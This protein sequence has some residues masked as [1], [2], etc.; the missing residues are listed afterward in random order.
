MTNTDRTWIIDSIVYK[1]SV[2]GEMD[3]EPFIYGS[4][5]S[6]CRAL[7][8]Q[9]LTMPALAERYQNRMTT[10]SQGSRNGLGK[11]RFQDV[12][13]DHSIERTPAVSTTNCK[14]WFQR[15]LAPRHKMKF[16]G[17]LSEDVIAKLAEEVSQ[18][19]DEAL[20]HNLDGIANSP[21]LDPF[22]T[23]VLQDATSITGGS[24]AAS[25]ETDI[26]K[27]VAA[28]V[29]RQQ[30]ILEIILAN[31]SRRLSLANPN[32]KPL[33]L[34]VNQGYNAQNVTSHDRTSLRTIAWP[35]TTPC[36]DIAVS[37]ENS[38]ALFAT[39]D[40]TRIGLNPVLRD[41]V[42][43]DLWNYEQKCWIVPKVLKR[44]QLFPYQWPSCIDS[45]CSPQDSGTAQ[46]GSIRLA[47]R[48]DELRAVTAR[49][50]KEKSSD[51]DLYHEYDISGGSFP[52]ENMLDQRADVEEE[53][54]TI[55]GLGNLPSPADAGKDMHESSDEL[56]QVSLYLHEL[57]ALM[58]WLQIWADM[59][60]RGTFIAFIGDWVHATRLCI[61]IPSKGILLISE[62]IPNPMVPQFDNADD[63][64]IDLDLQEQLI[65]QEVMAKLDKG[66]H[67][68]ARPTEPHL[69]DVMA[70]AT[71]VAL[72]LVCTGRGQ[73]YPDDIFQTILPRNI[74]GIKHAA[75]RSWK[76]AVVQHAKKKEERIQSLKHKRQQENKLT[77]TD[78]RQGPSHDS[79]P[80]M[81]PEGMYSFSLLIGFF[82][83]NSPNRPRP[84]WKW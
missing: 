31:R 39:E 24:D 64:K 10:L 70:G 55:L 54:L 4:P 21:M 12:D 23:A 36:T 11:R 73:K 60:I 65:A 14:H 84:L 25:C 76:Q 1:Y 74:K 69:L 7:R 3:G 51:R 75:E 27:G 34:L 79:Y 13:G 63:Y 52:D 44:N 77:T 53:F 82:P 48:G 22:L 71:L 49:K 28:I 57:D 16:V 58:A 37:L 83:H 19:C 9:W 59:V 68:W 40:G 50:R 2:D 20:H 15:H 61:R 35:N 18:L 5:Q 17:L 32:P 80:S 45:K 8:P 6:I 78:E 66:D 42:F 62:P 29:Q 47:A 30:K 26:Q 38:R 56:N 41:R 43:K 33:V 46:S 81:D 72:R 67:P